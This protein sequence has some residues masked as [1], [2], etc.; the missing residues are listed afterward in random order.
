MRYPCTSCGLCC[1]NVSDVSE[2]Q[3]LSG[4]GG[5]CIH[6]D[7][8]NECSIYDERPLLC[9]IDESYNAGLFPQFTLREFYEVN[10]NACNKLQ[11]NNNIDHKYIVIIKD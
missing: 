10:A 11:K 8:R 6:L 7:E 2:L 9:R 1:Q 4:E 3:E 5:A